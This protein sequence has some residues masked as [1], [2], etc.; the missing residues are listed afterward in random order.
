MTV[1]MYHSRS[2][3]V[4]PGEGASESRAPGAAPLTEL[5][6]IPHWRRRLSNFA[7]APF[8]LD[9]LRW[10]SVE[11]CFH[12][13]KFRD[14]APDYYRRFAMNSGS[15]LS[16]ALGG[17]VKRAGGRRGRPMPPEDRALWEREKSAHLERALYA[18]F[19]QSPADRALLL[20]T[21]DA[22]LTHRPARA[23]YV[24]REVELMR[25]RARLVAERG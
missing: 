9:G 25:V 3:D 17:A 14:R 4:P 21:G 7:E 8:T 23:R 11:H 24:R 12:A 1:L 6:A 22:T 13:A 5:A 15:E 19:N 10:R 18:R 16:A 20:A 2:A